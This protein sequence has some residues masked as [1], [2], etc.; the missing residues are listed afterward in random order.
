LHF[1]GSDNLNFGLAFSMPEVLKALEIDIVTANEST[2]SINLVT[3]QCPEE[4]AVAPDK[5]VSAPI[6][7]AETIANR[8][9]ELAVFTQR[10]DKKPRRVIANERKIIATVLTRIRAWR[11]Q[12]LIFRLAQAAG[13]L[14]LAMTIIGFKRHLTKVHD[15]QKEHINQLKKEF[16]LV[17][18]MIKVDSARCQQMS[19]IVAVVN[20]FNPEMNSEIKFKLAEEIYVMSLK[21]RQL[22]VALICATI[23]HESARSWDPEAI[24]FAGALGLMQILPSTGI[25]LAKQEGIA[26]TSAEEIL[27]NPILNVRLGCRYLATL[28]TEYGLEAGLAGYNGGDRQA[29]RWLRGGGSN[30]ELHPETAYYVPAILKIYREYRHSNL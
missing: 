7:S 25:E 8:D 22:D 16:R 6:L 23:T 20:R 24:S 26:W 10:D 2:G 4:V 5:T 17:K 27:F 30:S 29:K 14:I 9:N 1:A 15:Q 11:P 12:R 3:Q 13:L 21:Y 28:I 18:A 19:R